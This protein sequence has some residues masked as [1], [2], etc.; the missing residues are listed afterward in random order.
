METLT[1]SRKILF[2]CFFM[3]ITFAFLARAEEVEDE[4]GFSYDEN[5]D[6]GPAHWGEIRPEWSLCNNGN[7]QSPIDLLNKRVQVVSN[8]G[9][10]HR[11]YK[12]SNAT[13]K[14]RGHDMKLTWV[15]D[16][17]HININGT[18]YHL[19]QCHWHSPSE[20][21]IDGK[22][23]DLEAHLVHETPDGKIAVIGIM[24]EIGRPDTFLSSMENY[25][26]ALADT[27]DLEIIVG[28]VDPER[29]KFGSRKYYRYIGSLTI[30]PCTQNVVWTIVKK[31]RTVSRDQVKMIRE[32]VHDESEANARPIQPINN[33]LVKM[34]RPHVDK[35]D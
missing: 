9:R 10:L 14:N 26:K 34:Y 25:L 5:S 22:R 21:S 31:V 15:G 16:A 24:Y 19:K 4:R 33:R 17:G 30:P 13:L 3:L 32:A 35:E 27:T 6:T 12:P 28:N 18:S 2:C 29:I 8:L 23:Y 11:E 20:H 7:M 1:F